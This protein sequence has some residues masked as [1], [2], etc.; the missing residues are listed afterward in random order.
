MGVGVGAG[1]EL[2]LAREPMVEVVVSGEIE[3]P[4]PS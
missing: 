3:A 1:C 2:E 4:L